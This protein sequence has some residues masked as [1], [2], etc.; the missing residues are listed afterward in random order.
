MAL[1]LIYQTKM[2]RAFC[3]FEFT[4]VGDTPLHNSFVPV[5]KLQILVSNGADIHAKN[6]SNET[7]LVTAV[8]AGAI[9]NVAELLNLGSDY[10]CLKGQLE[11][12][13]D[14]KGNSILHKAITMEYEFIK[15]ALFLLDRVGFN[16]NTT[17]NDGSTLL[18]LAAS[19]DLIDY[20][21]PLLNNGASPDLA[22]GKNQT[23]LD[24]AIEN[25]S[26]QCIAE[27]IP[28]MVGLDLQKIRAH[29]DADGNSLLHIAILLRSPKYVSS[30]IFIEAII[31][32]HTSYK[33][34]RGCQQ[35]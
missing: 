12:L 5:Q 23:P 32:L 34:W 31:R 17:N 18:H 14:E 19:S 25:N 15:T 3:L 1:K 8:K 30:C 22:N 7:P 21:V 16:M 4:L 10:S 2:V 27:L 9:E 28:K 13:V 29:R 11:H 24:V 26:V 35:F 33:F 20:L 6:A